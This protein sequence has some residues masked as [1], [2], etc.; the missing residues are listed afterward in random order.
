MGEA[1]ET[2]DPTAAV[3]MY[4]P[5]GAG[6]PQ[7]QWPTCTRAGGYRILAAA[8]DGDSASGYELLDDEMHTCSDHTVFGIDLM[9]QTAADIVQ[10]R[11]SVAA[12]AFQH[13]STLGDE[14]CTPCFMDDCCSCDGGGCRCPCE[15]E[16][17]D[18][19]FIG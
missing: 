14:I 17:S 19:E 8:E 11:E 18:E 5:S 3:V 13:V 1:A 2:H 7:C 16:T 9:R 15:S 10:R 12:T 6:S 4:V